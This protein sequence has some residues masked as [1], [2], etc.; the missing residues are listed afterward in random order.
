MSNA[1]LQ[2]L[3]QL[4]ENEPQDQFLKYALAM[5]YLGMEDLAKAEMYFVSVITTDENYVPVYYQLGKIY[6]KQGLDKQAAASYEKGIA[7]AQL[8]NN[9]KAARELQ[10][11]LEELLF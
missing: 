1:R 11:A 9:T 7:A 6:E 2:K 8:K 3:L 4:H 5:E 10:A